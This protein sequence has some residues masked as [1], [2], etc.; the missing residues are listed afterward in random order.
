MT[1]TINQ[2]PRN[3]LA[4]PSITAQLTAIVESEDLS[5]QVTVRTND[6]GLST[7]SMQVEDCG[8]LKISI[9]R[10]LSGFTAFCKE[11]KEFTGTCSLD[12]TV[13]GWGLFW[14]NTIS[15]A[16]AQ[17]LIKAARKRE[18]RETDAA[19]AELS[20]KWKRLQATITARISAT[21]HN[22]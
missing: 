8:E 16:G 7:I 5:S 6:T 21:Q 22:G 10:K 9:Y 11:R 2:S 19:T 15:I 17:E 3:P 4:D 20:A 13:D 18:E 1:R 12:A 14:G